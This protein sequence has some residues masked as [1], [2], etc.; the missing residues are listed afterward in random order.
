MIILESL[1]YLVFFAGKKSLKELQQM[2]FKLKDE[3]FSKPRAGF[4]FNTKAMEKMILD[5][6]GEHM[7]MNDVKRPK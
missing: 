2:C 6:F 4:A 3:V 1:F 7:T 5:Q